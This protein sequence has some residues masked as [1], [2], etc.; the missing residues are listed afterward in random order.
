MHK[1]YANGR[2]LSPVMDGSR[3]HRVWSPEAKLDLNAINSMTFGIS[4]QHPMISEL[5]HRTTYITV[6]DDAEELFRGRIVEAESDFINSGEIYVEH[7]MAFFKDSICRPFVH[8]GTVSGLFS[9]LVDNHNSQVDE[10][11]RFTVGLC[12]VLP[13]G[14]TDYIESS[15]AEAKHTWTLFKSELLD[16]LGG[17][18]RTRLQDGV[19]YV[20]YI[21]DYGELP[22]QPVKFREN[23]LDLVR[24]KISAEVVT[25]LIP[26]G[27][28][29]EEEDEGYEAEPESGFWDG[30]RLTIRDVND[31]LDYLESAAGVAQFGQI[32]GSQT[33]D[34]VTSAE[35]LKALGT[36]A[37]EAAAAPEISIT[38]KV[39]DL[40]LVDP[41][42]PRLKL[43]YRVP[44][45]SPPHDINMHLMISHQKLR[46]DVPDDDDITL[47]V[48]YKTLTGMQ[49]EA[50]RTFEKRAAAILKQAGSGSSVEKESGSGTSTPKA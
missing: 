10:A 47:G 37:V 5:Q 41:D 33:F 32:W 2:L 38:A 31:G 36:A 46:F 49:A 22:D 16:K 34:E 45:Y 30:N 48:S 39:V 17:Y 14:G 7:E 11:R 8:K 12:T 29:F 26:Y 3:T 15:T 24:S 23:L 28:E 43:G 19:R 40:H 27:A 50:G 42:I 9:A 21:P 44:V 4:D 13:A 35:E 25:C 20:D 1:I 6:E 18:I